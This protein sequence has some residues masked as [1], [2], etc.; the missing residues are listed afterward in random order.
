MKY[1]KK[2][3]KDQL[4]YY[5]D[6]IYELVVRDMK[7]R[8]QSSVLG[9][10][11][12]LLTPLFQLVVYFFTFQLV[13]NFGI[14]KYYSF[15]FS[16]ILVWNWFQMSLY[17]ATGAITNNRDFVKRPGFPMAILPLVIVLTHLLHFILALPVLLL[18]IVIDGTLSISIL[19]VL[20]VLIT[21]QFIFTLSLAYLLATAN[22]L[23]R[24][25]QHI[26]GVVLQILFFLTPIFYKSSLVPASYLPLYRLNPM[27]NFIES[28]RSVLLYKAEPRWLI[29]ISLGLG[30]ILLLYFGYSVF[31]YMKYRFAEEL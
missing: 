30:S 11:W 27:V 22:V 7:I 19:Y 25:I 10:T 29:I 26:L 12:T 16:G 18:I 6:L 31:N 21:I 13:L 28:Y 1:I 24:D 20:P 23:L 17:E 5:C 4:S 3:N 15:L 9:F 14:P 2:V 8:Y